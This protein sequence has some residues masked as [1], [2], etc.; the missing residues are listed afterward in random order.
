MRMP[1]SCGTER[2][3]GMVFPGGHSLRKVALSARCTIS[4]VAAINKRDH[5]TRV[6]YLSLDPP[7]CGFDPTERDPY[8]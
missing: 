6:G 4:L 3:F 8:I 1:H 2:A 5:S 7:F